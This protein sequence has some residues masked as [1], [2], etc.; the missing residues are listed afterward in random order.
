MVDFW[1]RERGDWSDSYT[2]QRAV[3]V[4]VQVT[5]KPHP[6]HQRCWR[7]HPSTVISPFPLPFLFLSCFFNYIIRWRSFHND[8][9]RKTS[10]AR[11]FVDGDLIELFLDLK[12]DK[13]LE[14]CSPPFCF[15]PLSLHL[16]L[17]SHIYLFF[18]QA[19]KDLGVSVE[20]ACKRIESLTQAIH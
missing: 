7:L 13:M 14:V 1:I 18:S 8:N 11:N 9:E 17:L 5:T 16:L 4:P 19:V 3:R 2:T 6:R 10:E 20:E 12:H 15:S